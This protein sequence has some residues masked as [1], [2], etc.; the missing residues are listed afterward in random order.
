[1]NFNDILSRRNKALLRELIITDFKLRYQGSALGYLWSLFRPL[2]LFGVL[3]FVFGFMLKVGSDIPYYKEYLLLGI[4]L[5]SFF[6]EATNNGLR[7]IVDRGD[8]LRKIKFPRYIVVVSGTISALINLGISLAV[9][10]IFM[11][12]SGVSITPM[13]L[14]LPLL[15]VELYVFTLALSFLLSAL[16]VKFRDI[17]YVWELL[18]QAAFYATPILYPLSLVKDKSHL[19]AKL[20]LINPMAQIIQDARYILITNRTDTLIGETGRWYYSLIPVAIVIIISIWATIYFR[21]HS[22]TFAE[23]I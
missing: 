15:I 3:L 18:I 6:V 5:W 16:Y 8:L 1:M 19:L 22:R 2:F 20:L 21:K 10:F 7:A 13:V 17:S 4:V 14:L 12:F 9:V 11:A 23:D